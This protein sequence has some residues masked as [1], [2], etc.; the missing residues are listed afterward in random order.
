MIN[1]IF[2]NIKYQFLETIGLREKINFKKTFNQQERTLIKAAIKQ[3]RQTFLKMLDDGMSFDFKGSAG[4]SPMLWLIRN[5]EWKAI[6]LAIESGE[7][8]DY[9]I[10]Q[11][12]TAMAIFII[13]NNI[14]M[15][16]F[17]LKHG[18][19]QNALNEHDQPLLFDTI[20][21]NNLP[22]L[23]LFIENGA[24]INFLSRAGENSTLYAAKLNRFEMV[25]F[26]IK[27]GAD[28]KLTS[29]AGNNINSLMQEVIQD[30]LLQ[31]DIPEF[32]WMM[33]VKS[34]INET[35]SSLY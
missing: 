4:I 2:R 34:F 33:R 35:P 14:T 8:P 22:M 28:Y 29:T 5:E 16:E 3:E 10:N 24:D 1:R 9:S 18:S 17:F 11:Y 26:L 19:N 25:Y 15:A 23:K 12:S 30:K 13:Q 21:D 20:L 31:E 27:N 7:N 32:K 6:K